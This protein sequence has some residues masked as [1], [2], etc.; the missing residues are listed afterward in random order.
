MTIPEK[1]I[2]LAARGVRKRQFERTRRR[3]N[4]DDYV[5][6][7]ENEFDN[8]R[9]ALEAAGVA[10]LIEAL[11]ANKTILKWFADE[12]NWR[13]EQLSEGD[14][15]SAEWKIGFDPMELARQAKAKSEAAL[16]KA[17]GEISCA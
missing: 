10:E 3:N 13:K 9:A 2:D 5:T 16:A 11:N 7:T 1:M 8:A 17:T 14:V 4:Y 15:V 12:R 6:P